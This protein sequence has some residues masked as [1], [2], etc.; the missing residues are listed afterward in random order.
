MNICTWS[1]TYAHKQ[2][3]KQTANQPNKQIKSVKRH[4]K[5]K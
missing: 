1:N 4:R 3:N 2:T 5:E